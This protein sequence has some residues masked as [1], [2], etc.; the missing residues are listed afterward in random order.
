MQSVFG[1]VAIKDLIGFGEQFR[2]G[3]PDPGRA[4]AQYYVADSG[5]E[6]SLSV[7]M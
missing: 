1:V 6:N 4:V 7:A 5:E 2:G 3:V